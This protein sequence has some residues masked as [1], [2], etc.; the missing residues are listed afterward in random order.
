MEKKLDGNYT[1]MLRAVL[2][3]SGGQHPTK[4]LLYGHLWPIRKTIKVRRNRHA[5]HSWR[6][7]DK[8]ISD[9]LLWTPSHGRA[10]AGWP[11]RT[12]YIYNSWIPIQDVAWKT[13]SESE[14]WTIETGGERGSGRSMLAAQHVVDDDIDSLI[15]LLQP[16]LDNENFISSCIS[17]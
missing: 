5:G 9:V 2:N 14:Q 4:Q 8:L 17:F 15:P 10:K 7:K 12:T 13:S 11:A 6:S 3:K 16:K 1:R